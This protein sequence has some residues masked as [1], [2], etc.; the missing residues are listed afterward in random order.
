MENLRA[1]SREELIAIIAAQRAQIEVLPAR[2]EELEE[3][4]RRLR[5]GKGGGT[6]LAVKPSRPERERKERKRRA[7]AF[8]RRRGT[9]DEVRY[10]ALEYCP[11]CGRKLSGGWEHDRRQTIQILLPP[12]RVIDH[13]MLGRWCGVCQKRWLPR[14]TE[15]EI[16]A[17]GRRRFGVSV[18]ALVAMLHTGCRVPMKMIRQ[19]L[20]EMF[21]LRIS[22]GGSGGVIGQGESRGKSRDKGVAGPGARLPGGVCG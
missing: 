17:R 19:M 18:R 13:V 12:V 4:A 21:T 9:P 14:L 7:Q 15:K 11:D 10:H 8:V 6:A 3:E 5:G 20:R 1:A 2:V 22:G 16:G